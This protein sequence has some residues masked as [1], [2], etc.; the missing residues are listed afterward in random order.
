MT[1][2]YMWLMEQLT[3]LAATIDKSL[4]WF[5]KNGNK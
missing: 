2:V 1:E 4:E 5:F 3:A